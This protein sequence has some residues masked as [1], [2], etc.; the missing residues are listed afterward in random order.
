MST[1]AQANV[2]DDEAPEAS[3]RS[4]RT[5]SPSMGRA[6]KRR[7]EEPEASGTSSSAAEIATRQILRPRRRQDMVPDATSTVGAFS[8]DVPMFGSPFTQEPASMGVGPA[9]STGFFGAPFSSEPE[10]IGP[11]ATK[12]RR[13]PTGQAASGSDD[14]PVFISPFPGAPVSEEVEAAPTSAPRQRRG[15]TALGESG[16]MGLQPETGAS[17]VMGLHSEMSLAVRRDGKEPVVAFREAVANHL[18]EVSPQDLD[19]LER[20][21]SSAFA[22]IHDA[23]DSGDPLLSALSALNKQAAGDE[24]LMGAL[25]RLNLS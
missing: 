13:G 7:L 11:A 5:E 19:V 8:G 23:A 18:D 17:G 15:P 9:S 3:P 2:D 14:R 4:P 24:E 12:R 1:G 25:G 21:F 10:D 20:T 22:E 16:V 6:G